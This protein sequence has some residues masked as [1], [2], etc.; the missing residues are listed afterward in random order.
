MAINFPDT[1]GYVG[2]ETYSYNG[3]TWTWT[4]SFWENTLTPIQGPLGS[5]GIQG[6][7]GSGGEGGGSQ[8]AQGTLGAQGTSGLTLSG[9]SLAASGYVELDNGLHVIWGSNTILGN[10]QTTY[11]FP[12]GVSL[13]TFSRVVVSGGEGGTPGGQDQNNPYVQTCTTTGF[14]VF[15]PRNLTITFFWIG[16]G[17]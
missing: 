7:S 1:T 17:Y 14:T 5:Q 16:I 6:S 10:A 12:A 4:G 11:T 13:T 8:G 3:Y 9:S 15:N 2:G